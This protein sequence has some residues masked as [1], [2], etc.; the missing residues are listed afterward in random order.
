V[1]TLPPEQT[2][3]RRPRRASYSS[4]SGAWRRDKTLLHVRPRSICR[5]VFLCLQSEPSQPRLNSIPW[6]ELFNFIGLFGMACSF[7]ARSS[8]GIPLPSCGPRKTSLRFLAGVTKSIV[9]V[10]KI[11]HVWVASAF[12]ALC[13]GVMLGLG[14]V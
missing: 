10:A 6:R 8:S 5:F 12:G 1:S 4:P 3:V 11:P 13:F 9:E 7:L 2:I 14:V